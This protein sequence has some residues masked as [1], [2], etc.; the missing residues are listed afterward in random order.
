MRGEQSRVRARGHSSSCDTHHPRAGHRGCWRRES[1]QPT[2]AEVP[3]T[4]SWWLHSPSAKH[5]CDGN[6]LKR[7]IDMFNHVKIYLFLQQTVSWVFS[8][9]ESPSLLYRNPAAENP[10]LMGSRP[11]Y[12]RF[13][14]KLKEGSVMW[15]TALD[16]HAI[17]TE[18]PYHDV[19]TI[20]YS[21]SIQ[22]SSILSYY[23]RYH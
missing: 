14:R 8:L 19:F 10:V 16:S 18:R 7:A 11:Y 6:S 21:P 12:D 17:L 4:S 2:A 3:T 9:P 15:I 20:P 5:H 1:S 22:M 13:L 23:V